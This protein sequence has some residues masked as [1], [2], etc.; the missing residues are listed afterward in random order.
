VDDEGEQLCSTMPVFK[1][2]KMTDAEADS[3]VAYLKSIPAVSQ[4]NPESECAGRG[5]DSGDAGT[6]AGK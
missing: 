2:M 3:I 1:D 6:D 5:D 4:E